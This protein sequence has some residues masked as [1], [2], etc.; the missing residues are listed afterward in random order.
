LGPEK[1]PLIPVKPMEIIIK[2]KVPMI[3]LV[4]IV[5]VLYKLATVSYRAY[6]EGGVW[7]GLGSQV[8][9]AEKQI[10]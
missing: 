5:Y 6:Q 10:T 9:P 7:L 3:V 4:A 8:M 2:L 1:S